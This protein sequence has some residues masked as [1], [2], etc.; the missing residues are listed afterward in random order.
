MDEIFSW[1]DRYNQNDDVP[2]R[3]HRQM[4]K[5][6]NTFLLALSQGKAQPILDVVLNELQDYG[7]NHFKNEEKEMRA[8]DR[9]GF[10]TMKDFNDVLTRELGMFRSTYVDGKLGLDEVEPYVKEWVLRHMRL[11]RKLK[12]TR[13]QRLKAEYAQHQ[14]GK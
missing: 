3:E 7:R 14:K 1:N 10:I 6:A 13:R 2:D 12:A 8:Y 4:V 5:L 11:Q 9:S